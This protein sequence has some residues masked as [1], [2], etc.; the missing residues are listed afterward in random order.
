MPTERSRCFPGDNGKRNVLSGLITSMRPQQWVKNSFLFA[1][2]LF[3]RYAGAPVTVTD[4]GYVGLGFLAFCLLSGAVY[5]INDVLDRERDR[6]H[7]VKRARPIASG[8]VSPGAAVAWA[9][10]CVVGAAAL[11]WLVSY[12]EPAAAARSLFWVAGL[13]YLAMNLGYSLGLKN[14]VILDLLLIGLGFVVRVVAGCLA[15]PVPVSPWLLVC[16]LLLALFLGLCKRRHEVILLGEGNGATRRVLPKYSPELLN[17]MIAETTAAVIVAYVLY[18][19]QPHGGY[20]EG[21]ARMLLTVPFVIYGIW[22][23]QYLAYCR[24]LGGTPEA[25]FKDPSFVAN[26]LLWVAVIV[27]LT[28]WR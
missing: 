25:A 6:L 22:R 1:G 16:T 14:I 27:A 11:A 13:L 3:G 12:R 26:G 10:G 19:V 21:D 24:D 15:I 7:P 17:Q 5:L 8:R 20:P 4:L 18:A 9:A 23:Y 28:Y 2:A